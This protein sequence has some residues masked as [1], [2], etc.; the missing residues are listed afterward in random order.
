MIVCFPVA[1]LLCILS[2]KLAQMLGAGSDQVLLVGALVAIVYIA[3][4]MFP[5][6]TLTVRCMRN[7]RPADAV[8]A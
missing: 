7:S 1:V 4:L 6:L 2:V 5:L 8:S 3:A